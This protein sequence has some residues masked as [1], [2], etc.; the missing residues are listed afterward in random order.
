[1]PP[2]L[3][4]CVQILGRCVVC[5]WQM[6]RKSDVRSHVRSTLYTVNTLLL[7]SSLVSTLISHTENISDRKTIGAKEVLDICTRSIQYLDLL[8]SIFAKGKCFAHRGHIWQQDCM[9]L[10]SSWP[11]HTKL[12]NISTQCGKYSRLAAEHSFPKENCFCAGM[13][14]SMSTI[15]FTPDVSIIFI[16]FTNNTTSK[17]AACD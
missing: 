13:L 8:Q 14:S 2:L 6:H 3:T 10:R 17:L 12:L 11:H 4:Q 15:S 1:M 5:I 7:S 9:S 16:C